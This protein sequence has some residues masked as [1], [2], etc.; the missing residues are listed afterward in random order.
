MTTNKKSE[1]LKKEQQWAFKSGYPFEKDVFEVI[2]KIGG[3]TIDREWQFPA[4]DEEGNPTHRSLDFRVTYSWNT[5][6]IKQLDWPRGAY[7]KTHLQFLVEA[8]STESER[9]L[10]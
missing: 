5:C 8:K 3:A 1:S 4:K 6:N 9:F 7:E 2:K 10:F